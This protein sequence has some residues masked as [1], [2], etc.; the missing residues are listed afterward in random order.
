M[1]SLDGQLATQYHSC[2]PLGWVPVPVAGTY[3]PGYSARV[4]DENILWAGSIRRSDLHRS[5]VRETAAVMNELVRAGM[6]T[7]DRS[8]EYDRY[9]LTDAALPYYYGGNRYNDN[10]EHYPYL[11]YSHIVPQK[12]VWKEPI[13]RENGTRT[14]HVR[15]TWKTSAFAAW[16]NDAF[17]RERSI[18]LAPRE[19]AMPTQFTECKRGWEIVMVGS[20]ET[21]LFPQ[22]MH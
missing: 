8:S 19:R 21:N 20:P 15:F 14:F 6:L 13:H 7:G 11:C 16:A 9:Y 5:D 12:V 2:I 4:Q 3:Y 22:V 18:V 17:L 10:P 1:Q